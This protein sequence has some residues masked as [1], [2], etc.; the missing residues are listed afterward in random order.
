MADELN[1]RELNAAARNASLTGPDL[2]AWVEDLFERIYETVSLLNVDA[3]QA[4]R[5]IKLSG[6]RLAATPIKND[7]VKPVD[8]ALGSQDALRNRALTVE[9]ASSDNPLPISEHARERHHNLSDIEQL[10]AL[11]AAD[12]PG[13][14]LAGPARDGPGA[15]RT[16][17]RQRGADELPVARGGQLGLADAL[18][19][20]YSEP[21]TKAA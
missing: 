11:V 1:D 2:E 8:R 19:S 15:G 5:T 17:A 3:L 18:R 21:R 7:G 13:V 14:L 6:D 20:A 9:S 16:R 10:K 4:T 12:P